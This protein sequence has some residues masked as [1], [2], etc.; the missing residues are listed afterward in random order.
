ADPFHHPLR[1]H[2]VRA[3]ERDQ[4]VYLNIREAPVARRE[5]RL[6]RIA[7]APVRAREPPPDLDPRHEGRPREPGES[8]ERRETAALDR[9]EPESL[10]LEVAAD[11]RSRGVALLTRQPR[12]E[13]LHHLR[14]RAHRCEG[15]E[16][17]VAPLAEDEPSGAEHALGYHGLA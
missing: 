17:I 8:D 16:V 1:A 14:I 12:R 13:M 3:D 11:S 9:P 4:L 15:L 10:A 6:A 2:V 5:R 7:R